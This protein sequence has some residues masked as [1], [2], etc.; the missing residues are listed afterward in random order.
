MLHTKIKEIFVRGE[1]K[2]DMKRKTLSIVISTYNRCELLHKNINF[3]LKYSGYDVEFLISDNA[4][5]DDTRV[6]LQAIKDP[7]VKVFNNECN[8]GVNNIFLLISKVSSD[9]FIT[10]ND[11]DY[12]SAEN[13]DR[14][15]KKLREI[16]N[17]DILITFGRRNLGEGYYGWEN[18]IESYLKCDHP[19]DQVYN[20]EYF[21][22]A[23]NLQMLENKVRNANIEGIGVYISFKILTTLEKGYLFPPSFIVQPKD[24]EKIKQ[25]RRESYGVAFVLPQYHIKEFDDIISYADE[26][27]DSRNE[28][29][30]KEK[31]RNALKRVMGDYRVFTKLPGYYE[32]NN[33]VKQ[34]PG[35][36]IR[37]GFT[38]KKYVITHSMCKKYKLRGD[39]LKIFY[40]EL[41]TELYRAL[42]DVYRFFR[43]K[44]RAY[45]NK[46]Y[47]RRN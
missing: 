32:R 9:Y 7:R 42:R 47:K 22:N 13:I 14:L 31:Y 33:I 39:L 46:L 37:N 44:Y 20:T 41:A 24:R 27:P 25:T 36:W 43:N 4:S 10:V 16:T 6:M 1:P 35:E 29:I 17:I 30:I 26:N 8:Y 38:Y 11:R 40:A 5:E 19:G 12:I 45:R 21:K 23:V 18:F 15:C 34:G 2:I 3:M 28:F